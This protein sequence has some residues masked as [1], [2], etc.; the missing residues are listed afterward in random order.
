MTRILA[1]LAVLLSLS[2][3]MTPIRDAAAGVSSAEPSPSYQTE[4]D[5]EKEDEE[6][7]CD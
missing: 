5:K 3:V 7:D 4:E 2:F 6:P 1:L